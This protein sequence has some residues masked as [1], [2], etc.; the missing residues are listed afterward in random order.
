MTSHSYEGG[1]LV[2]SVT[3][4]EPEWSAD[5]L[6]LLRGHLQD[7]RVTRGTHGHPLHE[8]MSPDADPA[9]WDGKYRYVVPSPVRD[10]AQQ[11]LDNARN[12]YAKRFPDADLSALRWRVEK[13]DR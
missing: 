1:V 7:E 12:D 8:A 5:D 9:R 6:L 2:R 4:A 10:F 13:V 11:A 3:V